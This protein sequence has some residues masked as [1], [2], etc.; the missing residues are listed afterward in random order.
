MRAMADRDDFLQDVP[1]DGR[2]QRHF[3]DQ[4][5]LD[6]QEVAEVLLKCDHLDERERAPVKLH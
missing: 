5:H 4:I 1:A 6:P 3:L 2:F